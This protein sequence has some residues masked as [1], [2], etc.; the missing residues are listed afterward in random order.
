[1]AQKYNELMENELMGKTQQAVMIT[2]P[3][4]VAEVV[5]KVLEYDHLN[6]DFDDPAYDAALAV[7]L[8]QLDEVL[9]DG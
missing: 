4:E 5:R 8:G 2:L 6:V 3:R 1:M 9:R 7:A